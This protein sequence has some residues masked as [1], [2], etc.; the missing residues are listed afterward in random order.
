M[1]KFRAIVDLLATVPFFIQ[2][3]TGWDIPHLSYLR[4]FRVLRILRTYGY[5]RA[6]GACY[7]VVYYNREILWVAMLV[8]TFLVMLSSVLLYYFRPRNDFA[9]E[10]FQSIPS[11]IFLSVLMLTGQ[12]L[13]IRGS[14]NMPWYTKLMVG[15]TGG[16]SVVGCHVCHSCEFIDLGI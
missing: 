3:G 2:V 14:E 7:R 12:D 13:W 8:C 9:E 1:I 4:V 6:F 5:V 15:I 11:T 10:K 16:L